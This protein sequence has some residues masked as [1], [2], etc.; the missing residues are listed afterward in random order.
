[1]Q[2]KKQFNINNFSAHIFWDV[3]RNKLDINKNFGF[4][5]QR[6]LN[7]GLLHDWN[8]VYKSFGLKKITEEAKKI[9]NLDDRSLHFIAHLSDSNLDDFKC[10]TTKQSIPKHWNF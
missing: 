9:R 7:Y 8:L 4:V 2:E 3:D 6:V 5:L 1:M 10:Y